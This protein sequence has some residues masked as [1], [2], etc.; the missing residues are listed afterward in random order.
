MQIIGNR[1]ML[2]LY[3]KAQQ[4][5]EWKGYNQATQ[6]IQTSFSLNYV[7]CYFLEIEAHDDWDH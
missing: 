6:S 3:V 7:K 2:V 5:I 4:E 1:V